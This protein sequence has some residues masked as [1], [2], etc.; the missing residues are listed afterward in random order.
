M[1]TKCSCLSASGSTDEAE[2]ALLG[3]TGEPRGPPPPYQVRNTIEQCCKEILF[4]IAKF[5]LH[6]H[7]LKPQL[8]V[9]RVI[10]A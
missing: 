5:L 2:D 8:Y 4:C 1:G 6:I 3:G 7:R 10:A 9:Y